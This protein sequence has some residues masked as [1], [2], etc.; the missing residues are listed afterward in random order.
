MNS[1]SVCIFLFFTVCLRP[2]KKYVETEAKP[3]VLTVLTNLKSLT[4][5]SLVVSIFNPDNTSM[6]Y[7]YIRNKLI[8]TH[9]LTI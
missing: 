7:N 3:F 2:K 1:F 5:T 4:I 9:N 8:L 6:L